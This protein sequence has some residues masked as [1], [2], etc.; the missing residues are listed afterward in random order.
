MASPDNTMPEE[1]EQ[2]LDDLG[3]AV[4]DAEAAL[5]SAVAADPDRTWTPREL[6]AA[7]ENGWSNS[8]MSIAFWRLV[9]DGTLQ[10]DEQLTVHPASPQ[11]A[12][13]P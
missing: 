2:I 10:V 6:Q 4:T 3:S 7:A 9:S 5:R 13:T 1:S 12:P 11:V 8:V